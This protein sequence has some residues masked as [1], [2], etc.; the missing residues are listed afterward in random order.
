MQ[1]KIL[2][3]VRNFLTSH[4]TN[5]FSK[6]LQVKTLNIYICQ[7]IWTKMLSKFFL[8]V[9]IAGERGFFFNH[10]LSIISVFVTFI[11]RHFIFARWHDLPGYYLRKSDEWLGSLISIFRK[12]YI[13]QKH[14]GEHSGVLLLEVPNFHN[15]YISETTSQEESSLS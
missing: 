4:R 7:T 5:Y 2:K 9:F 13:Q 11:W 6:L 14:V 12:E 15:L 8:K 10:G 1:D 3:G